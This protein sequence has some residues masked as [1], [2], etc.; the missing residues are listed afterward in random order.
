MESPVW[1]LIIRPRDPFLIKERS[2]HPLDP[3]PPITQHSHLIGPLCLLT[4]PIIFPTTQG[5]LSCS[6]SVLSWPTLASIASSV[7]LLFFVYHLGQ[8]THIFSYL[9]SIPIC[10][11]H[12]HPLHLFIFL[13]MLYPLC[14][15]FL[16][17]SSL[18]Y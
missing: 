14:S 13:M 10:L 4:L 17:T 1:M 11:T 5:P 6:G 15:P 18:Y 16:T 8:T 2:S 7:L 12:S 3:N 9:H